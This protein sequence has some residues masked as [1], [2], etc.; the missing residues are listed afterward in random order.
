[1]LVLFQALLIIVVGATI[2]WSTLSWASHIFMT[3]EE[4]RYGWAWYKTF[5]KEF[6]K[7]KWNV[8]QSGLVDV[9]T[10]SHGS[11]FGC[12]TIR[13]DGIGMCMRTPVD[14]V[15]AW[16]YVFRYKRARKINTRRHYWETKPV[17]TDPVQKITPDTMY[18]SLSRRGKIKK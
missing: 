10:S 3:R 8:N 12:G 14:W 16:F 5:V 13:F 7:Y 11:K 18:K 6:N 9:A 1:M 15:L 4:S 2:V 17:I